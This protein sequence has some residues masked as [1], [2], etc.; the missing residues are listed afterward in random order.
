MATLIGWGAFAILLIWHF[1]KKREDTAGSLKNY[2]MY[3]L[4]E[5]AIRGDQKAKFIK[6]IQNSDVNDPG[7][8]WLNAH[9]VVQKIADSFG[10]DPSFPPA[11]ILL[12]NSEAAAHIRNKVQKL[13]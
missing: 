11:N 6:W 7:R 12:W 2:I 1:G 8:L 9:I 10:G 3:L 4:M 13:A 5:D